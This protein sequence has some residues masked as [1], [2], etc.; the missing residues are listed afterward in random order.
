MCSWFFVSGEYD[1]GLLTW[2]FENDFV[3]VETPKDNL[4]LLNDHIG[5][6]H[7]LN[8][9][10]LNCEREWGLIPLKKEEKSFGTLEERAR[11]WPRTI[12]AELQ[13]STN[14]N[15]FAI[16]EEIEQR[17]LN[18]AFAHVVWRQTR[19]DSAMQFVAAALNFHG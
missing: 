15:Y 10:I 14:W 11:L 9:S 2:P 7:L 13:A 16:W 3:L 18:H 6:T 17:I 4:P 5:V 8:L 1:L 12:S 19:Q